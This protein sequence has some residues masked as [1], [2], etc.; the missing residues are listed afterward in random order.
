M[1]VSLNTRW[2]EKSCIKLNHLDSWGIQSFQSSILYAGAC[3]HHLH[4]TYTV[5][6]KGK[7]MVVFTVNEFLSLLNLSVWQPGRLEGQLVQLT[8]PMHGKL[9]DV[10]WLIQLEMF[11]EKLPE[12]SYQ[13]C[14]FLQ[15]SWQ[16]LA[17]LPK[18]IFTQIN[19]QCT[20]CDL[21]CTHSNQLQ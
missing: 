3:Y 4:S 20:S 21:P 9:I 8:C 5:S 14:R 17:N 19:G 11:L 2:N 13:T 15:V 10:P 7:F 18:N 12:H 6:P 16:S 1:K